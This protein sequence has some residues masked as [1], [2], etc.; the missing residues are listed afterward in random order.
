MKLHKVDDEN[1][2]LKGIEF[3]LY[4]DADLKHKVKSGTT[5]VD[6]NLTFDNLEFGDYY[7]A[8]TKGDADHSIKFK[9]KK[10]SI[11]STV[12]NVEFTEKGSIVN[13]KKNID[14]ATI[15]KA[16]NNNQVDATWNTMEDEK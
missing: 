2:P 5:D 12:P 10:I 4:K 3:T 7:L 13:D 6:G 8:E 16:E 11:N 14:S 1:K 9:T 15:L